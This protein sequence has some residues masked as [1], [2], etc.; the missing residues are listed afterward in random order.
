MFSVLKRWRVELEDWL[1]YH[2]RVRRAICR[3]K[4]W[5]TRSPDPGDPQAVARAIVQLCAAARLAE[6]AALE[7][8]IQ[9]RIRAFVAQLDVARLDWSEFVHDFHDPRVSKAAILKPCIGPR[10]KGVLFISFE[11]QWIKLL[12]PANFREL[13][14]RYTIVIAPSSSPHNL[15]N[16]VF[17]QAFP[18]PIVT[19]ISNPEDQEVLPRVS[20]RL[21]VA[22]LYASH[23]VNPELYRPLP[24]VERAYD[25][26]MVASWGKVKRHHLL[27]AALRALPADLRVLLVGQDQEGRNA[28]TIR[29]LANWYGV[30][31]RFTILSNQPYRE[32]T[33]LFCQA[34]ASVVLSRREGSCLVVAESLCADAPVALL[35]GAVLGSRVFINEQTGRFLDEGNMARDL[36]DF[37]QSADRYQ[38]RAWAVQNISC[39]R[40]SQ[41]LND[42]LKAKALELGQAWTQDIAPMQWSPDPMLVRPEDRQRAIS[43]RQDILARFG[44]EI[45]PPPLQ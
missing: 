8:R 36:A 32:V 28:D 9:E 13:A 25:L 45:G 43:E 20:N 38:P 39:L 19:L 24:K 7:S 35:Q 18:E 16:Y 6:D 44:L 17:P 21:I 33:R 31:D 23:W 22:P 30:G 3:Y 11:G 27:F 10:E 37:V 14:E 34:R 1:R 15:I 26:I 42:L 5:R 2:P 41:I 4:L 12:R 29:A 40:S